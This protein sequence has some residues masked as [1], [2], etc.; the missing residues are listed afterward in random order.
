[1]GQNSSDSKVEED[2]LKYVYIYDP[3]GTPG[4]NAMGAFE[5]TLIRLGVSI[6]EW[7]A[8]IEDTERFDEQFRSRAA[9]ITATKVNFKIG[10]D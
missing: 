3:L 10:Q 9:G 5:V 4:Y 8:D 2:Y 7:T 1:M 6:P